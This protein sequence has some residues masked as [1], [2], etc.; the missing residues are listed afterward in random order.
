MRFVT[1]LYPH[2]TV[3]S[4]LYFG[5]ESVYTI[6]RQRVVSLQHF[7]NGTILRASFHNYHIRFWPE[8]CIQHQ[9]EIIAKAVANISTILMRNKQ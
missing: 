4:L 6:M 8:R 2:Q 5:S 1:A 7:T 3:F 9:I